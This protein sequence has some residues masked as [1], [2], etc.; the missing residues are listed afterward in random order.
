MAGRK[1]ADVWDRYVSVFREG[2]E[3]EVKANTP[4]YSDNSGRGRKLKTI[5][6]NS[7]I[8]IKPVDAPTPVTFLE[9]VWCETSCGDPH[10]GWVR[11]T[12]LKKPQTRAG[13]TQTFKM[14]PQDFRVAGFP[15]DRYIPY[16]TYLDA[17]KRAIENRVELPT[18]VKT[19]LVELVNYCDSHSSGDR[20]D[21]IAA[22]D[23]L[24]NSAYDAVIK[25]IQKDFSEMMAP[26]CVLERG[27][28][29]MQR[30]GF[31][32]LNKG[33]A[34][35]L[36]PEAGNEPLIDFKLKDGDDREYPFSVKVLSNT[37]NVIKPQ[38]LVNFMDNN[39]RD[40]FM[41]EFEKTIQAKVLRALSPGPT[42]KGV[43]ETTYEAIRILAQQSN[44]S[45]RFPSN[46]L[47]AIP[48]DCSSNTMTEAHMEQYSSV[49][50]SMAA[51]YYPQFNQDSQFTDT[52]L[53]GSGKKSAKYNQVSLIMQLAIQ[54]LSDDGILQYRN[55]VVD[56]LM[57]KVTY[58]K[59][60]LGGN[61]MPE[62]KMENK[63]F[64]QLKSTDRFKLRAKSYK[65]SPVND[66]VGIQP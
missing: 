19:F 47:T 64:N 11:I 14:K 30:L 15:L 9:V 43:A 24:V 41:V 22:Y 40:D 37:T 55:I 7:V 42:R 2:V 52:K 20:A 33:N 62:F 45:S 16:D 39:S 48:A 60:K 35:V 57:N 61:G 36:I 23:N 10:E 25:D 12:A 1:L 54:K 56:Y 29:Q 27:G 26:I 66:R 50:S 63:S 38:D 21:L 8:H 49:W 51:T 28:S 32:N 65:S 58:Y 17:L 46:I 4:L 53:G 44:L 5:P 6:K 18:V 3:T 59:F 31:P 34:S 13:G